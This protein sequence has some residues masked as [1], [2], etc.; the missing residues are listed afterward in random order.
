MGHIRD[1]SDRMS[2]R[3]DLES[4]GSRGMVDHRQEVEPFGGQP[5][6]L[7]PRFLFEFRAASQFLKETRIGLPPTHGPVP[8]NLR[9]HLAEKRGLL[10]DES[11]ILLIDRNL[12]AHGADHPALKATEVAVFLHFGIVNDPL[13]P[14]PTEQNL[15]LFAG[16]I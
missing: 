3:A 12:H 7:T 2:I 16:R 11:A 6:A 15:L 1:D 10:G 13:A 9:R 5:D 4:V 8:Q 14:N